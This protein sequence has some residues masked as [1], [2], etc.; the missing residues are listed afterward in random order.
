MVMEQ[1]FLGHFRDRF[2]ICCNL[3]DNDLHWDADDP[4][5]LGKAS[6]SRRHRFLIVKDLHWQWFNPL[7]F[8]LVPEGDEYGMP[9]DGFIATLE[10]MKVTALQYA[11]SAGG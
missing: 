6:M 5:W 2:M 1:Q 8:G 3:A 10:Q 11:S 9:L 4:Q 7:A